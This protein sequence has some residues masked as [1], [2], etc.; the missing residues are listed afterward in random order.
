MSSLP[1]GRECAQSGRTLLLIGWLREVCGKHD[2]FYQRGG[3]CIEKVRG[4]VE[5]FF[6]FSF[7]VCHFLINYW[8]LQFSLTK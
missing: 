2:K 6:A 4:N 3:V 5:F 1:T 7:V 8:V